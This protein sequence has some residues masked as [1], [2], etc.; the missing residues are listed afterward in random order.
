MDIV[1]PPKESLASF[2]DIVAP[3]MQQVRTLSK[4]SAA[5]AA[6]R[7]MLLPMLMKGAVM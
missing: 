4:Q 6:T 7:D 3:L 5:L 1:I 2:N